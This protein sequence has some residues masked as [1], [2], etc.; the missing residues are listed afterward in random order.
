MFIHLYQSDMGYLE[1]PYL[2]FVSCTISLFLT[3]TIS[4][5]IRAWLYY[6]IKDS[7]GQLN[8][9]LAQSGPGFYPQLRQFLFCRIYFD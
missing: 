4:K 6:D 5:I 3:D 8:I 7:E 9:K 2:K 1:N